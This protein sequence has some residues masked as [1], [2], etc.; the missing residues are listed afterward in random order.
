MIRN[1]RQVFKG[2]QMPMTV[3]MLVVLLGMVAYLA[4][5][6]R[7]ANMPDDLIA[8]VYGRS[9]LRRDVEQALSDMLRRVGNQPN[10]KSMI[11]YFQAQAIRQRVDHDGVEFTATVAAYSASRAEALAADVRQDPEMVLFDCRP[12]AA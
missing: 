8:R 6:G 4:P 7:N 1:F 2:N 10:A 5:S 9:V 3:V 12:H 11:P